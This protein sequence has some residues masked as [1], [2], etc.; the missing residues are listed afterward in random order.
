MAPRFRAPQWTTVDSNH[1]AELIDKLAD[2]HLEL[3][4]QCDPTVHNPAPSRSSI[5]RACSVINTTIVELRDIIG[6]HEGINVSALRNGH[7]TRRK[8]D[9][10][11]G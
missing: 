5:E 3:Y 8:D 6:K 9:K 7:N 11:N 1:I 4:P 10:A 2:L